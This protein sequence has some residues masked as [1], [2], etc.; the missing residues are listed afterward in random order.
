MNKTKKLEG[1][2]VASGLQLKQ[3]NFLTKA[4]S[5]QNSGI[6]SSRSKSLTNDTVPDHLPALKPETRLNNI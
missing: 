2:K 4:P 3:N 1:H 5:T 6:Q